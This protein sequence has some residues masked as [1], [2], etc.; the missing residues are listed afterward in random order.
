MTMMDNTSPA[1]ELVDYCKQCTV[2]CGCDRVDTFTAP[3]V[4]HWDGPGK[5]GIIAYYE[6]DAGHQWRCRWSAAL[7]FD[8]DVA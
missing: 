2:E 7:W 4:I 6:C 3:H 1:G 8:A 5:G